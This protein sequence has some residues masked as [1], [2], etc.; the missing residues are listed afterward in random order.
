MPIDLRLREKVYF[1]CSEVVY[2][3]CYCSRNVVA[4]FICKQLQLLEQPDMQLSGCRYL[5]EYFTFL[6]E[7]ARLGAEE[8]RFLLKN[9]CI[10][11]IITFY[12]GGGASA[13][14]PGSSSERSK[15]TDS[16][17]RSHAIVTEVD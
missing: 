3:C 15:S 11:I 1:N 14:L 2:L 16:Q 8:K 9:D 4:G 17:V 13:A 6:Y 7:F 10:S 12:L 5:A